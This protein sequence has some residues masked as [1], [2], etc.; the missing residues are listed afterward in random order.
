MSDGND[1]L[2]VGVGEATGTK[3]YIIP[4]TLIK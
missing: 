3:A 4:G 2:A 1:E